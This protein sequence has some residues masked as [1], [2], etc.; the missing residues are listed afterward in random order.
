MSLVAVCCIFSLRCL[1]NSV[2]KNYRRNALRANF[3]K[4]LSDAKGCISD[5]RT[6][7]AKF[8]GQ[9]NN[10]NSLCKSL[11]EIDE[12]I[13]AALEPENIE[14][15]VLESM[16]IME[17]VHEILAEISLKVQKIKVSDSEELSSERNYQ[18]VNVKL[19]KIEFPVFKG[20]PLNWQSFYDQFNVSI[21][22]NKTLSDIDRF[23]YLKIFVWPSLGNHF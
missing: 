5:N 11:N 12:Q 16:S 4:A 21:H 13:L 1:R 23:N 3:Q 2:E 19:P 9:Q 6:T 8:L 14:N 20:N 22:Q 10:L 18:N 7:K 17:P 15:D